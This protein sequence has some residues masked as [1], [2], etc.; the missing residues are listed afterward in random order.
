MSHSHHGTRATLEKRFRLD[1][2]IL[3]LLPATYAVSLCMQNTTHRPLALRTALGSPDDLYLYKVHL[4][5]LAEWPTEVRAH[6]SLSFFTSQGSHVTSDAGALQSS[7]KG[8][9]YCS[10]QL[11]L[12]RNGTLTT[13]Y[14]LLT[15]SSF[16]CTNRGLSANQLSK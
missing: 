7:P 1:P 12:H 3:H 11:L 9:N 2:S 13:S 15:Y 14:P 6:S 8:R 16:E 5:T 10:H 4:V